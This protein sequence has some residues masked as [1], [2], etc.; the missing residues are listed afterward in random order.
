MKKYVVSFVVSVE[1]KAKSMTILIRILT[2]E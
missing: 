2:A 1:G